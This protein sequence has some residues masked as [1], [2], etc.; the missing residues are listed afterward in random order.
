M[1]SILVVLLSLFLTTCYSCAC[2]SK[3]RNPSDP[4]YQGAGVTI[5]F[6]LQVPDEPY[7]RYDVILKFTNRTDYSHL[8]QEIE[9]EG[10][11]WL[12]ECFRVKRGWW[13]YDRHTGS[14]WRRMRVYPANVVGALEPHS[15]AHL[16]QNQD[17]GVV[18]RIPSEFNASYRAVAGNGPWPGVI[19]RQAPELGSTWRITPDK[20]TDTVEIWCPSEIVVL[21]R[22]S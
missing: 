3:P 11:W 19:V 4:V 9:L 10:G 6:Y 18:T 7:P 15:F 8:V 21:K 22:G 20:E 2:V 14:G 12:V 5:E 1:R 13:V 17:G 16:M